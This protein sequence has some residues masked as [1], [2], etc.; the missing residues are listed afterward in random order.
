MRRTGQY[1]QSLP[2]SLV[3]TFTVGHPRLNRLP[4][5]LDYTLIPAPLGQSNLH[6]LAYISPD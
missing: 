6:Q 4:Q 1:P 5:R 2:Y 3:L